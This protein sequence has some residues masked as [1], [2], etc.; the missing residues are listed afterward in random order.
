MR[1]GVALVVAGLLGE[2]LARFVRLPRASGYALAGL[3]LGPVAMGWFNVDDMS[4]LRIFI[5][6]ALALVLFE[7]G[8]RVDLKWFRT[9]PWI[10][11]A[12]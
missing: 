9:N 12:S 10:I 3:L 2:I 5:D 11:P 6:L 1:I 7:L 8:T 4:T